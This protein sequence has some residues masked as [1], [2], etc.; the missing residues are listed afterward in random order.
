MCEVK[1]VAI[2]EA[3][4]MLDHIPYSYVSNNT[5]KD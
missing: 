2:V 4:A 3:R 5:I 1:D